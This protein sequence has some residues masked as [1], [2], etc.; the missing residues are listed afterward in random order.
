MDAGGLAT[1][2]VKLI[3]LVML[4]YWCKLTC[5]LVSETLFRVLLVEIVEQSVVFTVL[6]N[7]W[8]ESDGK[9]VG[10]EE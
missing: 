2:R 3:V 7:D 8:D 9:G 4:W 6:F 5:L 10:E 1:D